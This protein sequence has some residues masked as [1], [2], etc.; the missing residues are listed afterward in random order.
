SSNATISCLRLIASSAGAGTS[1]ATNASPGSTSRRQCKLP[2]ADRWAYGGASASLHAQ[3]PRRDG[4]ACRAG[5]AWAQGPIAQ[6]KEGARVAAA[7]TRDGGLEAIKRILRR[8]A[9]VSLKAQKI[10]KSE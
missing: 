7:R 5:V 9:R 10:V 6:T 8:E 4:E 3:T 1:S 2:A